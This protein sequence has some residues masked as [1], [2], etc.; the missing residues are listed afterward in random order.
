MRNM[1]SRKKFVISI[2]EPNSATLRSLI[3]TQKGKVQK[4]ITKHVDYYIQSWNVK[5]RKILMI[6][7][8]V[9]KVSVRN[10]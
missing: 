10:I 7:P 5:C 9:V 8:T 3:E 6:Y 4:T 2:N 1:W